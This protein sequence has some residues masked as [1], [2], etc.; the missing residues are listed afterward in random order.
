MPDFD[1][2][3]EEDVDIITMAPENAPPGTSFKVGFAPKSRT[4]YLNGDLHPLGAATA[5]L[6]AASEHVPYISL[7]AMSALYPEEW[8][9]EA[10]QG[11]WRRLQIIDGICRSLRGTA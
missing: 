1:F 9:R 3:Y 6:V 2:D 5:L 7:G 10:C 4:V 8:L 11:D